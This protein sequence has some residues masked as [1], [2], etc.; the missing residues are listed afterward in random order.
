MWS[1][2]SHNNK[3]IYLHRLKYEYRKHQ[4]KT[5]AKHFGKVSLP[6]PGLA[7]ANAFLTFLYLALIN[8]PMQHALEIP[9][10][11]GAAMSTL[12]ITYSAGDILLTLIGKQFKREP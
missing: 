6:S 2:I 12:V 4:V 11:F 10:I 7:F 1:K 5:V 9:L 3:L 8:P